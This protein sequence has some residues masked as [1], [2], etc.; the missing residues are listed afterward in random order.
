MNIYGVE[1]VET[2]VEIDCIRS[3]C[4]AIL[5]SDHDIQVVT[6]YEPQSVRDQSEH[7]Q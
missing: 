5:E 4:L 2:C 1:L 7:G 6:N 3:G